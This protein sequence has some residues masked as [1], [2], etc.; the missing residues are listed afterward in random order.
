MK[1]NRRKEEGKKEYRDQKTG[2]AQGE[3]ERRYEKIVER[4]GSEGVEIEEIKKINIRKERGRRMTMVK[5]KD[6][7]GKKK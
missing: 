5:L 3:H 1:G 2:D 6:K 4:N 7:E